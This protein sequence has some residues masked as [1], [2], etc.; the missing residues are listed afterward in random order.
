MPFVAWETFGESVR[1]PLMSGLATCSLQGLQEG[2]LESSLRLVLAFA[3]ALLVTPL[4]TTPPLPARHP[5][6][7]WSPSPPSYSLQSNFPV[8]FSLDLFSDITLS[9]G[10]SLTILFENHTLR[11][12]LNQPSFPP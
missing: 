3:L 1:G 6:L 12:I 8:L 11:H 2:W 7:R 9:L 10:P 5:T 4:L